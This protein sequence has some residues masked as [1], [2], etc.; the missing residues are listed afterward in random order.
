M[1]DHFATVPPR[2]TSRTSGDLGRLTSGW[3]LFSEF[4]LNWGN[5]V[6][7][8]RNMADGEEV[9]ESLSAGLV[10]KCNGVVALLILQ[11]VDVLQVL[12]P[13]QERSA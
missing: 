8:G 4:R 11:P 3:E 10:D 9:V 7:P 12:D 1:N 6:V 2:A 5:S 13:M